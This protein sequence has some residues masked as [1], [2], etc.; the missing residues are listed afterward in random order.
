MLDSKTSTK[1]QSVVLQR[2][3]LF[4]REDTQLQVPASW[5]P[6]AENFKVRVCETLLVSK[7]L[8][9]GNNQTTREQDVWAATKCDEEGRIELWLSGNAEPDMYE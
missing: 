2:L 9:I 7:T 3:P 6:S 8:T 1:V 4:L 5:V